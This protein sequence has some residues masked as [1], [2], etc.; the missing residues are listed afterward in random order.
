VVTPPSENISQVAAVSEQI[1][2]ATAADL[3][4]K[5]TTPTAPDVVTAANVVTAPTATAAATTATTNLAASPSVDGAVDDDLDASDTKSDPTST[6]EALTTSLG[7]AETT[8]WMSLRRIEAP[9]GASLSG[10]ERRSGPEDGDANSASLSALGSAS[11]TLHATATAK[12]AAGAS[13][14]GVAKGA[15]TANGIADA[16]AGKI[17]EAKSSGR[18]DLHLQLE[19]AELGKVRIQVTATDR[20]MSLRMVVQ[21]DAARQ[22]I[23]AQAGALRERLGNLGVSLGSLDVRQ[24]GGSANPRQPADQSGQSPLGGLAGAGRRASASSPSSATTGRRSTPLTA[25]GVD[26]IV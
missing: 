19:P 26:L 7:L 24:E 12:A 4:S 23:Q 10:D 21:D 3:T 13:G 8:S 11:A 18:V 15:P 2:A 9:P 5:A 14:V 1:N 25:T 20:Q 6:P 22:A 16:I 17:D